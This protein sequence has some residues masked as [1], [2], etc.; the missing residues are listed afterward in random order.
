MTATR[1]R[2]PSSSAAADSHRSENVSP[3]QKSWVSLCS[4]SKGPIVSYR[5]R[6]A[7][8]SSKSTPAQKQGGMNILGEHADSTH[9]IRLFRTAKLLGTKFQEQDQDLKISY[10]ERFLPAVATLEG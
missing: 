2:P 8:S 6:T 4:V 9:T 10:N 1:N 7:R 5:S 3:G